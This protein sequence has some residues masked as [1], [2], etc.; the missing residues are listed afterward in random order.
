MTRTMPNPIALVKR[1]YDQIAAIY[2][3]QR[4]PLDNRDLLEEFVR[5]LPPRGRVLDI[6]CG[7]G[8]PVMKFLLEAECAVTG[9]DISREMLVL[10]STN[11][12]GAQLLEMNM[13]HVAFQAQSCDGLTAFY[14]I[15]HVPRAY[16][17]QVFAEF[18]GILKPGG[19]MLIGLGWS[20]GEG[21]GE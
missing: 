5:L 6:D 3:A 16:H 15:F 21:T 12:P 7:A 14:T 11:V 9:I 13:T 18:A 17:R 2:H 1:G 4:N 20:D 8:V 10:A 19:V